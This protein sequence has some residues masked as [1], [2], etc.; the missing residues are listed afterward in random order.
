MVEHVSRAQIQRLARHLFCMRQLPLT[1]LVVLTGWTASSVAN[2]LTAQA[3]SAPRLVDNSLIVGR[4]VCGDATWLFTE[5]PAL[6]KVSVGLRAVSVTRVRGFR[7]EDRPW[8]LA[9][10]PNTELWTLAAPGTLARLSSDG[11]VV[12]RLL[13]DQPRLGIYGAGDR[14]LL[15]QPPRRVGMPLLAA[16]LPRRLSD[17]RPWPGMLAKRSPTREGELAMNLLNCGVGADGY[18]PCWFVRER[19]V[20]VS[21]GST[22]RTSSPQLHSSRAS[23][24]DETAPIWDAAL[25]GA[26][27]MWILT[28]SHAG[29]N[30]RPIGGRLTRSNRRGED[31]GH[32]D[33]HPE[34]RVILSATDGTCVYLSSNGGLVEV[35]ER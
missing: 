13:L 3:V 33:L 14:L 16:G 35:S 1:L 24:V 22:S 34:A 8:G 6:I 5:T 30:G 31:E 2:D 10:L 32:I 27:R 4:A 23:P 26:T 17:L 28:T 18:V 20:T 11:R 19:R 15:Q 21:D 25:S 29:L 12:E 9:C 7:A